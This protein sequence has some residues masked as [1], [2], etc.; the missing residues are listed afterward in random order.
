MNYKAVIV[1]YGKSRAAVKLVGQLLAQSIPPSAISLIDN[2]PTLDVDGYSELS[3]SR[4]RVEHFPENVG[5]SRGCNLGADGEWDYVV[6]IN[7]DIEIEDTSLF[8]RV[9]DE[10]AR[11][12]DLGCAGVS[13]VNPDKTFEIVARRFPSVFAIVAKRLPFLAWP[14]RQHLRSYLGSY[15]CAYSSE[16]LHFE[17]DWLQSSFLVVP[18]DVWRRCGKFDERFFVFMADVEYGIRVAKYGLKSYL[19]PGYVVSAD[20]VRASRG[21]LISLLRSETVRIHIKDAV[22]Y[23]RGRKLFSSWR[24]LS[25]RIAGFF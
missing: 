6:F 4:V 23:F 7:P 17:V 5:Y 22:V 13:Q 12:P 11:I 10:M 14:F 8:S 1:N 16:G 20:G 21:G 24:G 9:L 25:G 3:D 15:D 18:K 2:S 19:F